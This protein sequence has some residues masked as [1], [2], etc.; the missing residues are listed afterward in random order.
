MLWIIRIM[1]EMY[2]SGR[3]HTHHAQGTQVQCQVPKT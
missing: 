2:L 1:S 3:A